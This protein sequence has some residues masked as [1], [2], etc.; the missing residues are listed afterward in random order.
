MTIQN[1][2]RAFHIQIKISYLI[3]YFFPDRFDFDSQG[4]SLYLMAFLIGRFNV[5]SFP[6]TLL[7]AP[8]GQII[9][10]NLRGESLT[11]QLLEEIQRYKLLLEMKQ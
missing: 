3:F 8:D 2:L 10:E 1:A 7:L 9:A 11:E 5:T 4:W 6:T